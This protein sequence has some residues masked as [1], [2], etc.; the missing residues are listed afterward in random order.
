MA[1]DMRPERRAPSSD[2]PVGQVVAASPP[3]RLRP[4]RSGPTLGLLQVELTAVEMPEVYEHVNTCVE[5]PES[6]VDV[7]GVE[8]EDVLAAL[9]DRPELENV[10]SVDSWAF[11]FSTT[12]SLEDAR[13]VALETVVALNSRS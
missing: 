4:G 7:A 12:L 1:N 3:L 9:A 13:A 11:V 5:F 8:P 2:D 10:D 6:M